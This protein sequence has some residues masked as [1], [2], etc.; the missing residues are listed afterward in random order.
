MDTTDNRPESST[1]VW[2]ADNKI[3]SSTI[4]ITNL[5]RSDFT[6]FYCGAFWSTTLHSKSETVTLQEYGSVY[7]FFDFILEWLAQQVK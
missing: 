1:D 4:E 3:T 2:D 7:S 6:S 5:E